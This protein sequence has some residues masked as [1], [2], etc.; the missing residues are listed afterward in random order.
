MALPET[1]INAKLRESLA[2][3]RR[4]IPHTLLVH[5]MHQIV[6]VDDRWTFVGSMNL[7]S[8][9]KRPADRPHES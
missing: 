4:R 2:E 3:L 9:A 6:V 8:H 5:N 1:E 7:L